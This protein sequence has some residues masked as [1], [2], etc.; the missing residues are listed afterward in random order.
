MSDAFR[1][2]IAMYN[3]QDKSGVCGYDKIMYWLVPFFSLSYKRAKGN[4]ILMC[5]VKKST[6]KQGA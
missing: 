4:V 2:I 6:R 3:T 1:V 5:G